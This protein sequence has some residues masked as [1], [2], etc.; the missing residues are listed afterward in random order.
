MLCDGEWKESQ[1]WLTELLSLL[2]WQY[3]CVLQH[4]WGLI[5]VASCMVHRRAISSHVPCLALCSSASEKR[6]K[7]PTLTFIRPHNARYRTLLFFHHKSFWFRHTHTVD[8][9][10][11]VAAIYI[12]RLTAQVSWLGLGVSGHPGAQSAFI[13]WTGWTL[14]MALVMTTAPQTLACVLLLLLLTV[15][16]KLRPLPTAGTGNTAGSSLLT[17]RNMWLCRPTEESTPPSSAP[18]SIT[19]CGNLA[20]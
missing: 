9:R 6:C 10:W 19:T 2:A 7:V 14:A 5:S 1:V 8:R 13:K 11:M 18:F 15:H 4:W 12:G 16:I 20:V 17:A 3:V